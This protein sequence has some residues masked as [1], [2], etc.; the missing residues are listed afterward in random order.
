MS[1]LPQ[2]NGDRARRALQRAGW[3]VHRSTGSQHVL[4]N[5]SEPGLADILKQ[6]DMSVDEFKELL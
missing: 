5:V 6:A 3:Y 2:V 4:K 1:E